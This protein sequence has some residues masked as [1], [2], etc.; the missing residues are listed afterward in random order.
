ML[1][2]ILLEI[3]SKADGEES[4]H[5]NSAPINFDDA[6]LFP[7]AWLCRWVDAKGSKNLLQIRNTQAQAFVTNA[8]FQWHPVFVNHFPT[9]LALLEDKLGDSA[10]GPLASMAQ[11]Q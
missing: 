3:I 10:Q 1:D 11:L 6:T 7:R 4:V 2:Q 8:L 5:K 9:A